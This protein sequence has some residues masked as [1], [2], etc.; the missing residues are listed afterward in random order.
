MHLLN[1]YTESRTRSSEGCTV[2]PCGCAHTDTTWVQMCD[3][4]WQEE[5]NYRNVARSAHD[6]T[7]LEEWPT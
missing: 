2:L 1:G 3:E 7:Q 5:Q 4:H 6:A